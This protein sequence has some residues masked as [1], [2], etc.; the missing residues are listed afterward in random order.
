[1]R[2]AETMKEAAFERLLGGFDSQIRGELAQEAVERY[3]A[4]T[5]SSDGLPPL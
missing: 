1:V 3:A 4:R 5:A 2:T